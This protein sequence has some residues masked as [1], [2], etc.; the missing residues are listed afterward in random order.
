MNQVL[1]A[2]RIGALAMVIRFSLS[3]LLL[4]NGAGLLSLPIAGLIASLFERQLARAQC[5]KLLHG[6]PSK[7]PQVF[8]ETL[9]V[10]WPNTWRLGV[11]F[12]S[13]Y[14]TIN[15]NILICQKKFGL[16]DT[17]KYGLAIQLMSIAATMSSVWTQTKWPLIGQYQARH[18]FLRLRQVLWPRVW[19]QSLTFFLLAGRVVFLGPALLQSFGH[20]KEMLPQTWMLVLLA[21]TFL[22]MQFSLWTTLISMGN[23]LPQLW[24]T[25][26]TNALGL[27]LSLTLVNST[28]L[29][30]GVFVL[31][32]LVAGCL[33]NYWFWPVV[34]AH[35]TG[36]TLFRF[37]FPGPASS[38]QRVRVAGPP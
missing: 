25:V 7:D 18:E 13:F 2:A 6:K 17:G 3:V 32:P 11:Q 8:R 21:V 37:L 24:H 26:A 5:L 10:I 12:L 9:A 35:G 15:A 30:L 36:T 31:G 27:A 19:L 29:G 34:A 28:K 33:F 1:M 23:H 22:E 16:A 38:S 4:S 14:F 20:G